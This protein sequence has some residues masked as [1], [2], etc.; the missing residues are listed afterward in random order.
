MS[1]GTGHDIDTAF[2]GLVQ[3]AVGALVVGNDPFFTVAPILRLDKH[4]GR[5]NL[6][7]IEGL[8]SVGASA[9]SPSR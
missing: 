3:Q 2:A 9:A 6:A 5:K 4:R 8:K 1:A 7:A